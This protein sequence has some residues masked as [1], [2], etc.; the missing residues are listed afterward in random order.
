MDGESF[1][2]VSVTLPDGIYEAGFR[3]TSDK[4][5]GGCEGFVRPGILKV[6]GVER[7][8]QAKKFYKESCDDRGDGFTQ[9]PEKKVKESYHAFQRLGAL[10]FRIIPFYGKTRAGDSPILLLD[11]LRKGET[12]EVYDEKGLHNDW[13]V[14]NIIN[15]RPVKS[16]ARKSVRG[17]AN[18]HEIWLGFLRTNLLMGAHH[19]SL[20]YPGGTEHMIT[21]DPETNMGDIFVCDVG[22]F[23]EGFGFGKGA[24]K[25]RDAFPMES[26]MAVPEDEIMGIYSA[27]L[28][29]FHPSLDAESL[30]REFSE[31]EPLKKEF[32]GLAWKAAVGLSADEWL[33]GWAGEPRWAAK[34]F[35]RTDFSENFLQ[36]K[37]KLFR[38][39]ESF[40]ADAETPLFDAGQEAH[41]EFLE[42]YAMAGIDFAYLAALDA[43]VM[44]LMAARNA[45]DSGLPMPENIPQLSFRPDGFP[46][47]DFFEHY[48]DRIVESHIV[49]VIQEGGQLHTPEEIV[50]DVELDWRSAMSMDGS[51]GY[52]KPFFK[53][54]RIKSVKK[55]GEPWPDFDP[56]KVTIHIDK[57]GVDRGY[58]NY[59]YG[60]FDGDWEQIY[61]AKIKE[62][63]QPF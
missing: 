61:W 47:M 27:M 59:I 54:E 2:T 50:M 53:P 8:V 57:H 10:G 37:M 6:E 15:G 16:N 48:D 1:E 46:D 12:R 3:Y 49:Q 24:G 34:L 28:N 60:D 26:L 58:A 31:S 32:M 38:I 17:L 40:E 39:G 35:Q 30:F 43:R 55:N 52:N 4:G 11:D 29:Q 20:G 42:G 45:L 51:L 9:D 21:R 14:E 22:R 41:D 44:H 19:I 13:T 33:G 63:Q 25:Y 5:F 56:S 7:L 23:R 36:I 62:G 18:Y